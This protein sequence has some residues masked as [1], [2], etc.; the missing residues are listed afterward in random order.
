LYNLEE[1]PSKDYRFS[2]ASDDILQHRVRNLDWENDWVFYDS[3]FNLLNVPDEEFLKFLCETLH[4]SVQPRLE[5]VERMKV[6]I[7]EQLVKDGWQVQEQ[8]EISGRPVFAAERAFGFSSHTVEA[9]KIVTQAVDAEYVSR[10]VTRMQS[11]LASEPDV[12]IGTAKEFLET[13]C[14]TILRERKICFDSNEKMPRLVKQLASD[15]EPR[16]AR[17]QG[18]SESD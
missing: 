11:A 18:G 14:K 15:L 17:H 7:N 10:Q 3:R 12:A 9:T 4:P 13:I 16:T 2:N 8:M 1:M 5:E 6:L